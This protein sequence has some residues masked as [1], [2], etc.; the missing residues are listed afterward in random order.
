MSCLFYLSLF[1]HCVISFFLAVFLPSFLNQFYFVSFPSPCFSYYLLFCSTCR[2]SSFLLSLTLYIIIRSPSSFICL[3]FILS[4]Y[5]FVSQRKASPST[6]H[7]TCQARR[8]VFKRGGRR[9]T[10]VPQDTHK[11]KE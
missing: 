5:I 4:L 2:I 9:I 7:G 8:F 3:C 11:R 6:M 10:Y 1:S